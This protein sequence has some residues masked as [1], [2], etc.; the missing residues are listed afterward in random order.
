[1]TRCPNCGSKGQVFPVWKDM[2]R[3]EEDEQP[4]YLGCTS[5]NRLVDVRLIRP[6]D[7]EIPP[8]VELDEN[9]ID[10][11]VS[12]GMIG[13]QH[14]DKL[15]IIEWQVVKGA[16]LHYGVSDWRSVSDSTLSASENVSLMER[17]GTDNNK[18]TV[19]EMSS[20]I[21]GVLVHE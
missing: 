4:K 16:A 3:Y 9:E 8:Q 6:K 11:L 18:T 19:R 5:C 20:R 21:Y 2:Q 14:T 15:S 12:R 1:M 7:E 17:H 13:N 10:W